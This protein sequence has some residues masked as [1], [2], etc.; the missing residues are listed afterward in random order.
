M[1]SD[2]EWTSH[3]KVINTSKSRYIKH[4]IPAKFSYFHVEICTLNK[5]KTGYAHIIEDAKKFSPH[6]GED[7]IN[8]LLGNPPSRF[9][10]KEKKK[11]NFAQQRDIVIK[12]K[13]MYKDFDITS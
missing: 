10:R 3:K 7:V 6:F 5:A 12:F 2:T 13:E 1:Q 4:S 11:L 8:D 9:G